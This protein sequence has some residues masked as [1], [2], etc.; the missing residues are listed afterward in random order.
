MAFTVGGALFSVRAT[1]RPDGF[2][3][4]ETAA[5]FLAA[6][7]RCKRVSSVWWNVVIR[8]GRGKNERALLLVDYR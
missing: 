8:T 3:G 4:G 1:H 5:A 7:P 6:V 2:P